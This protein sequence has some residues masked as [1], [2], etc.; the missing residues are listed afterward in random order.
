MLDG[1]SAP[2]GLV[3]FGQRPPEYPWRA[4]VSRARGRIAE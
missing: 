3:I 2:V 1:D 4:A